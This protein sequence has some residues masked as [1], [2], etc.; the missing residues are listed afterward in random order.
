AYRCAAR[1]QK[2]L[3]IA[4]RAGAVVKDGSGEGCV[5][6]RILEHFEKILRFASAAGSDYRNV[7]RFAHRSCQLAIEA[8]L[9][10]IGIHRGQQDLSGAQLFASPGPLDGVETLVVAPAAC[11]DV[12]DTL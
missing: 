10:A 2:L 1:R 8:R 9:N 11:I 3:Q 7:G 6:A 5:S 4:D 12:P